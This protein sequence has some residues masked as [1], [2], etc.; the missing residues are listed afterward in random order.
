MGP[1]TFWAYS[2]D[3]TYPNLYDEK[4]RFDRRHLNTRGAR[5]FSTLLARRLASHWDSGSD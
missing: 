3:S 2:L 4:N 1:N 5:I